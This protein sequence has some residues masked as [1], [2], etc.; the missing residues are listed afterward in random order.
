M[1]TV[2]TVNISTIIAEILSEGTPVDEVADVVLARHGVEVVLPYAKA[3][4]HRKATDVNR[5]LRAASM[6][7]LVRVATDDPEAIEHAKAIAAHDIWAREW[8]V[9]RE[10]LRE[11][12]RTADLTLADLR[13]LAGA[14]RRRAESFERWAATFD[15]LASVLES[16][17]ARTLGDV[18]DQIQADPLKALAAA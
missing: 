4:L 17:G 15:Y 10:G 9:I 2:A 13:L 1:T 5:N 3:F 7:E 16:G 6:Q 11:W 14:Y 8:P 18:R 12:V